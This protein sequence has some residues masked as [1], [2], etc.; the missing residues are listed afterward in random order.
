MKNHV[1]FFK[2]WRSQS[3]ELSRRSKVEEEGQSTRDLIR[4]RSMR[5]VHF[6]REWHELKIGHNFEI[7]LE[8]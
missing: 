4:I 3:T 2:Y 5:N 6:D 1:L 7:T 8:K